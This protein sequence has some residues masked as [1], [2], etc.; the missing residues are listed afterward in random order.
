MMRRAAP[1]PLGSHQGVSG[2]VGETP[3]L[4]DLEED[5]GDHGLVEHARHLEFLSRTF[6]LV[7]TLDIRPKT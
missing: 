4:A 5:G 3:R 2:G 7:M 1:P 6:S